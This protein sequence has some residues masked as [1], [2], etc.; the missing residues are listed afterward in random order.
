MMSPLARSMRSLSR[1]YLFWE[2]G[3]EG[4]TLRFPQSLFGTGG[5]GRCPWKK[6]LV[7]VAIFTRFLLVVVFFL[8]GCDSS[9]LFAISCLVGVSSSL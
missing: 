4:V 8:S 2:A 1:A 3:I 6:C 7:V 5:L 9:C